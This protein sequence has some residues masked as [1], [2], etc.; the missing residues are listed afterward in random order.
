MQMCALMTDILKSESKSSSSLLEEEKIE[1]T[2]SEWI[3]VLRQV[4]SKWYVG[5]TTR[6]TTRILFEHMGDGARACHFTRKYKP[7][8]CFS[9]KPKLT[10]F[11]EITVT[12]KYMMEYGIDNVRGACWTNEVLTA[13]ERTHIQR[14]IDAANQACYHCHQPGHQTSKCLQ[15]LAERSKQYGV[16]PGS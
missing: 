15:K 5:E 8:E 10:K 1:G 7:I 9:C 14:L 6:P 2:P 3:Y 4:K 13:Q 11:D 16:P 12:L